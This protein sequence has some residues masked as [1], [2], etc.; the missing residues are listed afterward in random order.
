MMAVAGWPA[1]SDPANSQLDFPMAIG[2]ILISTQL[3][4]GIHVARL[5]FPQAEPSL[6]RSTLR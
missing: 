1:R 2:L 4:P 6:R 3:L 5:R